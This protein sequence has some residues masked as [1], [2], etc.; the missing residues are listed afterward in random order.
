MGRVRGAGRGDKLRA[1]E[2]QTIVPSAPP[3]SH[4]T[5]TR[6]THT[7]TSGPLLEEGG[8]FRRGS[9]VKCPKISCCPN[10]QWGWAVGSEPPVELSPLTITPKGMALDQVPRKVGIVGY[11]RLGESLTVWGLFP[12]PFLKLPEPLCLPRTHL[13]SLSQS[14]AG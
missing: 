10:L 12:S 4:P 9:R 1:P 2:P 14:A 6:H 11:G 8:R 7:P 5:P 13:P 3:D